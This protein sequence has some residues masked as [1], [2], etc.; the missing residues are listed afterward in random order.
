MTGLSAR[1]KNYRGMNP[2]LSAMPGLGIE[3]ST[4][5]NQKLVYVLGK[6]SA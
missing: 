6:Q 1:R 2:A 4:E 5:D 3:H